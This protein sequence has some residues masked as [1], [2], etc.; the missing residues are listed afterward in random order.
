M[1]IIVSRRAVKKS[2]ENVFLVPL[3]TLL[4]GLVVFN[5]QY[6]VWISP[7][8]LASA[9][10][11]AAQSSLSLLFS[12]VMVQWLA[13][14]EQL[15]F[16][17]LTLA[18]AGGWGLWKQK[19]EKLLL[20]VSIFL[21]PIIAGILG[22]KLGLLPGVPHARTYFYLQPFFLILAALGVLILGRALRC[23]IEDKLNKKTKNIILPWA[24]GMI[25]FIFILT[26]TL[27]NY[28]EIYIKRSEREP[29]KKV[30]DFAR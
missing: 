21:G 23:C 24:L 29:L 17:F 25:G 15:K 14:F 10:S 2:S 4:A 28:Q 12:E 13:P 1:G 16:I 6:Y 30:L 3:I 7:E 18:V 22:F 11:N 19:P 8:M 9:K 26:A 27:N 20:I 5:W